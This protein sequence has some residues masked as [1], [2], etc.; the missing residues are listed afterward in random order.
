M[1]SVALVSNADPVRLETT[2]RALVPATL[3][4]Q[5]CDVKVFCDEPD[6]IEPLCDA[7]GADLAAKATAGD[8][9]TRCRG[10]W[11]LMLE[12]GAWPRG[13]WLT[14]VAAHAAS[15]GGAARFRTQEAVQ[16]FWRKLFGRAGSALRN[17]FLMPIDQARSALRNGTLEMLPVGRAVRTLRADLEPADA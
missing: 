5:V 13:D 8:V 15:G 14:V 6:A 7:M 9:L 10:D 16:P 12:E 1:L 17:G 4:G 3:E 2:L 11:L